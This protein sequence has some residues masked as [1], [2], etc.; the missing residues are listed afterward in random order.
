M[1]YYT[2]I[3]SPTYYMNKVNSNSSTHSYPQF[4]DWRAIQSDVFVRAGIH[5]TLPFLGSEGAGRFVTAVRQVILATLLE[6]RFEINTFECVLFLFER[7]W[8]LPRVFF[9]EAIKQNGSFNPVDF[10]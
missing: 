2:S 3:F 7:I 1:L 8:I 6:R 4:I 10:S 9:V 5:P